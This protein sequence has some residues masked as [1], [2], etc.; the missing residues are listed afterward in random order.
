MASEPG[1]GPRGETVAGP[2]RLARLLREYWLSVVGASLALAAFATFWQVFV[3]PKAPGPGEAVARLTAMIGEVQLRPVGREAWARV[4]PVQRLHVG[5]IVQTES[6]AAAEISFDSGSVVHVR[7]DT[8]VH[9]G[10]I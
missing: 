3:R 7:P 8:V 5:D 2:P 1:P 4:R 10:E 6:R 9:I